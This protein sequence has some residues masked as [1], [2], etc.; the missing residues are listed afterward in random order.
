VSERYGGSDDVTVG[1]LPEDDLVDI[2]D[3]GSKRAGLTGW[4]ESAIPDVSA[5]W[6]RRFGSGVVLAVGAVILGLP[7]Y[8][9]LRH[10]SSVEALLGDL[11]PLLF[12]AV[13][14][15]T[16]VWLYW[17]ADAL[18]P[19]VTAFWVTAGFG[20]T[21]AVSLYILTLH[22]SHG[23][24]VESPLF[25]VYE[26][27][28]T[29]AVGG[30]LVSRYDVRARRR[31]GRLSRRERQFRAVFEGTLDALVI[32]DDEGRYVAANPAAA[33][34]FG[35]PRSELVGMHVGDFLDADEPFGDGDRRRGEIELRRPD[36]EVR[37]VA[38]AATANVLP[39]HH[40]SA[41]HDVTDRAERETEV[42]QERARVQFLNRLL[43]HN[44]L[45]GMNL[46]M[47][48]LDALESSVPA[49]RRDDFDVIRHRSEEVVDLVQTARRLATDVEVDRCIDVAAPL[50][51]AI[52]SVREAYP[53]GAVEYAPPEEALHVQADDMLETV[54]DNLLTNAFEHN[55][56]GVTV[57]VGVASDAETVT[58]TVADDGDGIPADRRGELFGDVSYGHARDWGGFGLSIVDVLVRE[59]GG[60]VWVDAN[61]PSGAVF[62]VEL[63][64]AD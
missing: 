15:G 37:T 19:P 20:V 40:L 56:A 48:K 11:V 14:I 50:E 45:N 54:F 42:R 10:G 2:L 22:A 49:D 3:D 18:V 30:L 7:V 36:G 16:A 17:E 47:A 21:S 25:L 29:G 12:G 27:A 46:V 8:H 52:S 34:L 60:Q 64:R 51:A 4:T 58:V 43:R 9:L 35:L 57:T 31:H 13:L 62:G 28:A 24:A 38:F 33:D 55:D 63:R 41:L 1:H 5:V 39:G 23:H 32:T 44:V 59:Y 61:D 26:L 53:D 6:R